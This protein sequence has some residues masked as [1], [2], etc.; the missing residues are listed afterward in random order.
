MKPYWTVSLCLSAALLLSACAQQTNDE[1]QDG[2]VVQRETAAEQQEREFLGEG[3]RSDRTLLSLFNTGDPEL[4]V[5]V[6]RYIWA[7][8]LEVLDFLPIQTV[9]SF[10][11]VIVTGYGTPP[12]GGRAY[13]ATVLVDDPALDARSLTLAMQTRG[14]PVSA[15]TIR[16]IEDAILTRARQLRV[17]DSRL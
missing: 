2:P 4:K 1:I 8:S 6:N 7:A 9:D 13:R 11:G 12:G 3:P 16:A 14:G 5:D 10:T 15:S 17:A